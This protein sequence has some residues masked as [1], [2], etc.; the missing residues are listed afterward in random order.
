MIQK[1]K[2]SST[3]YGSLP[4]TLELRLL[5]YSA[6]QSKRF[7]QIPDDIKHSIAHPP[8][9]NPNRGWVCAGQEKSTAIT[10]FEKGVRNQMD[11]VF[12]LKVRVLSPICPNPSYF[13]VAQTR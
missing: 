2:A 6:T 1:Y 9:A 4:C 11:S 3:G 8:R 7:F 5:T 10:D 12:D 13:H